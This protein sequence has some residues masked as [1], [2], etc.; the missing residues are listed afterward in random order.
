MPDLNTFEFSNDKRGERLD[1]VIVAHVAE[2]F[3]RAQVQSWIEGGQVTVDDVS[4]KAGVR[5]KGGER[6]RVVLLSTQEISSD[7]EPQAITLDILYED[8]DIVVINKPAGLVVHP[9]VRNEQGTLLNALLARYPEIANIPI[10][11]KRRGIVHR[12]DKD[13]SGIILAAR[14]TQAMNRLMAQFQARTVEKVYLT[15]VE[16]PPQTPVG[17]ID[18]PLARDPTDRKRMAVQ[19]NGRPAIT[20]FETI[21]RFSEG[22][23]LLRIHLL[24][25]RTHQ[26]RV[27]MAF[28]G[29][30]VVGDKVYGYR[31]QRLLHGQFLHATRLC[32]DHPSTKVRL[33]FEAPLPE[34]LQNVLDALSPR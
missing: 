2:R 33:C 32:F 18:A 21:E 10:A 22:Q 34:R 7:V 28:I 17:R 16:R 23:T 31:R 19:R 15:L 24:T 8:D 3:S 26:I 4:M 20:E 6:I 13:T 1:K 25:G 14:S 11:A 9:G 5:L 12:L 30:P 27:H 29:C